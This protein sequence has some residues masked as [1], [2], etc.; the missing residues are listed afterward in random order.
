MH[1]LPFLKYFF[2]LSYNWNIRIAWHMTM[3]DMAGEKKYNINTTGINEL[4]HLEK[5]GIDISHATIYMPASY[6]L[7]EFFFEKSAVHKKRHFLDVGCG[8]GR[9]L[10]VAAAYGVPKVSGVEFSKALLTHAEKN[11]ANISKIHKVLYTLK[12]DD[13]FYF[14]IPEDVDCIFLFNPFDELI[15]SGFVTNL[16]TSLQINPRKI[17]I[18]YFNPLQKHLLV[19]AGFSQTFHLQKLHYLEGIILE[20]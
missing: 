17:T 6:D 12:N 2:Y 16:K 10:C 8:K 3:N 15:M 5:K 18:I 14:E 1:R 11:L 7:L 9:A 20:N 19:E 13:A 4:K